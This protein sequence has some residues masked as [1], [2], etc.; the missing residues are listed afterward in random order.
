[1]KL[2][3]NRLQRLFGEG[4]QLH[5]EIPFHQ[6]FKKDLGTL[7]VDIDSLRGFLMLGGVEERTQSL[8]DDIHGPTK[9][10][11]KELLLTFK[12][13]QSYW[14]SPTYFMGPKENFVIAINLAYHYRDIISY[15][16][17]KSTI[18]AKR[19]KEAWLSCSPV[20]PETAKLRNIAKYF[21]ATYEHL[22]ED[23]EL[24]DTIKLYQGIK[25]FDEARACRTYNKSKSNDLLRVAKTHFVDLLKRGKE[26][27]TVITFIGVIEALLGRVESALKFLVQ[28]ADLVFNPRPIYKLMSK[29]F[30]VIRMRNASSFYGKKSVTGHTRMCLVS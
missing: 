4:E 13:T 23:P 22:Y 7:N 29:L 25:K 24:E 19:A 17:R 14:K 30:K 5:Q 3:G 12:Q 16:D 2:R 26:Q 6:P 20:S 10:P 8:L 21:S 11:S 9:A 27:S 15:Y 28:A 18:Y 1:M